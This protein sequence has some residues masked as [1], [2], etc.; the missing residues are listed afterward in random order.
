MWQLALGTGST[1][2]LKYKQKKFPGIPTKKYNMIP[3]PPTCLGITTSKSCPS[4]PSHSMSRITNL[5]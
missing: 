4:L 2:P 1:A 3:Q 5:S